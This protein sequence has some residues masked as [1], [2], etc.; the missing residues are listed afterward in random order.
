MGEVRPRPEV[1]QFVSNGTIWNPKCVKFLTHVLCL[2]GQ[3]KL[4]FKFLQKLGSKWK[5]RSGEV[6]LG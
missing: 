5:Q 3:S 4:C 1:M 6:E 2:P